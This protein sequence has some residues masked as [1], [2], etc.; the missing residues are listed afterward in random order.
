LFEVF[1]VPVPS[2]T[3]GR[4]DVS[5]IPAQAVTLLNSPFVHFQAETWAERA[6]GSQTGLKLEAYLSDLIVQT[7]SRPAKTKEMQIL[8]QYYQNNQ[9][10]GTINTLKKVAHLIFMSKEFVYLQ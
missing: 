5:T 10:T 7:Y 9:I 2:K 4:R 3:R 1:D 8:R 6:N